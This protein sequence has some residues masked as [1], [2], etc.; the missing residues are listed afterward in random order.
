MPM[1][2]KLKTFGGMVIENK[3]IKKYE[4]RKFGTSN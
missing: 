2:L 1:G 3:S 4:N